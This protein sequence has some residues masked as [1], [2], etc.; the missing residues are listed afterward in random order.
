MLHL[1]SSYQAGAADDVR[2]DTFLYAS[3]EDVVPLQAFCPMCCH[4]SHGGANDAAAHFGHW[5]LL[6]PNVADES[7]ASSAPGVS[8]ARSHLE[9]RHHGVD[10]SVCAPATRAT[11]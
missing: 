9:Q 8:C 4:D 10:I 11:A 5:D 6:T 2:P 7:L 3:Y 1:I